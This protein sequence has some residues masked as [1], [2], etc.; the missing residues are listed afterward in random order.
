VNG[1]S[2][3]LQVWSISA[4]LCLRIKL[5]FY[6]FPMKDETMIKMTMSNGAV[7]SVAPAKTSAE[8]RALRHTYPRIH[9]HLT[10]LQES[11]WGA[12]PWDT[13]GLQWD[14]KKIVAPLGTTPA[15]VVTYGGR[16]PYKHGSDMLDIPLQRVYAKVKEDGNI[17][18]LPERS[19]HQLGFV[20]RP[21]GV[22]KIIDACV[23]INAVREPSLWRGNLWADMG[24]ELLSQQ[25]RFVG[26]NESGCIPYLPTIFAGFNK[27]SS[28]FIHGP[29]AKREVAKLVGADPQMSDAELQTALDLVINGRTVRELLCVAPN[30]ATNPTHRWLVRQEHLA[31][32][33]VNLPLYEDFSALCGVEVFNPAR[34]LRETIFV[35]NPVR[36]VAIQEGIDYPGLLDRLAE[37]ERI[38]RMDMLRTVEDSIIGELGSLIKP[39]RRYLGRLSATFSD[40]DLY[41]AIIHPKESLVQA[42]PIP[43]TSLAEKVD[44]G[45]GLIA[46]RWPHLI[47]KVTEDDMRLAMERPAMPLYAR[48]ACIIQHIQLN[49][50]LHGDYTSQELGR[51]RVSFECL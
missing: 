3:S 46:A 41:S 10:L 51:H 6:G 1:D 17:K 9:R 5:C 42:I 39:M 32:V 12:E 8:K 4:H 20:A 7:K 33:S 21:G 26:H 47:G 35:P 16:M 18:Y 31:H 43:A 30:T 37:A 44:F 15:A 2:L 45:F 48:H 36:I 29:V 23:A 22:G 49:E 40:E 25:K 50:A 38:S 14:V 24:L 13:A 27:L 19:M 34:L 11:E 28:A